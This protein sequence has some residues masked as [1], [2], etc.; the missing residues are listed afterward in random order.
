MKCPS[1]QTPLSRVELAWKNPSVDASGLSPSKE[2]IILFPSQQQQR[3][4]LMPGAHGE[5]LSAYV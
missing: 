2:N 3:L 4:E 5:V 1:W